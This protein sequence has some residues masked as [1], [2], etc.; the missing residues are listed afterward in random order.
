MKITKNI[1]ICALLVLMLLLCINACSANETLNETLGAD[2]IDEA[3]VADAP[4]DELSDDGDTSSVDA[5]E[6][7]YYTT[8]SDDV[9]VTAGE[10]TIVLPEGTLY[11]SETGSDENSGLSEGDSISTLAHAVDI[12]KARENKTATVYVLNGDYTTDAIDIGDDVGVSLSIIG[13]EKGGVTIHGNGA[14]VFDV[15]GD[16]LVWNFKNLDFVELDS[17]ARTSAALVLYSKNGNFTVDNCNFRDINSKLGAIAIGND[18]GNTNVT[19]CVIEDVTGSASSTSVLT[20]NGDGKFILD[21]VEIRNC[22]L[23]RSIASSNTASYLRT[24]IYINTYD[25]DVTVSNS[26]IINNKGPA[27]SLIESRSKL[28]IVNTTI[29]GNVVNTSASG[30]NGGDNLIW[31]NNDNS[32]INI[33]QCIIT[34]NTI[35]KSGKGLFYNQKGS[36]NIEYCD[37]SNNDVDSFVG[38]SGTITANNNWWGSNDQPDSKVDSWV[39]MNVE[40]DDSDLSENNKITLTVDFNHVK[41]SSG[42]VEELTGGEIPKD[43]YSI[44]LSAQNG[45]ITPASMVVQKGEVKSQ[46][47]TVTNVND[48]ITIICDAAVVDITVEGGDEPSTHGVIYV[49]KTGDDNNNG[50][51]EAPVA[52]LAKAIELA[53]KG[54][55]QIVIDEGTYTGYGYQVTKDL[56]I[57]GMGKVTLDANNQG[58]LFATGYPTNATKFILTNLTLAG[59]NADFGQVINSYAGELILDNVNITDNPGS[60]SLIL[61]SGK[62]TINNC[63]IANH[64]GG[65]V[66]SDSSSAQIVINNTLFENNTVTDYA[67]CYLSGYSGDL[68]IENTQFINNTGKLGIVKS[69]KKI[70]VKDSKFIDNTNTNSYG[71]AICDGNEFTI[72]NSTFINNKAARDGGAVSI[73]YNKVATITKSTFINNS[74]NTEGG[75]YYGDAIYNY[76]KLTVNYCV[77]LTNAENSLIYSESEYDVNAQY[78]WWGTNRNPLSLNGVGTYEDDDYNDV[79]CVIDS[80]NWVYMKVTTNL[81]EN[82]VSVGDKVG[83]TVD[84]TNYIDS[85]NALKPLGDSIPEVE[86]SASAIYGSL[87]PQTQTTS[88]NIAQFTYTA[89]DAGEDTVTIRSANAIVPVTINGNGEEGSIIYVDSINGADTNNGKTRA[90]AVKTIAHALEIANGQIVLMEGIHKVDGLGSIYEDLNITGEGNAIIDAQNNNRI[91]YVGSEGN[92]VISNVVMINGYSSEESGAL[93][94]NANYLTLIN[95]TLANSSAGQNYGG[96]IYSVGKL[97]LINTTIANC[98][99][100]EG[101]AIWSNNALSTGNSIV[102]RNSKLINNTAS[103]ND[104]LGGGAIFTQQITGFTIANTSFI[105]NKAGTTSSGGAIFISHSSASVTITD[106]EFIGNHA[107]G[108]DG[109]GGGAIYRTGTSNYQR[110]GTMTITNTLFENNTCDAN[111]GAIY[112][113]STTVNV[114]NSVLINNKDANGLAVYG[115]KTEQVSP[116]I[117]LNDNWWGSNDSPKNLVGG[118][119]NYK[120]T[121]NRWAVLTV[122]NDSEIV[123][124]STVKLTISINNYTTGTANGT[125]S[126]PITVPR[127]LNIISTY[128]NLNFTLNDGEFVID[129]YVAPNL[130]YLAVNVDNETVVLTLV[131]SPVM[132]EVGDITAKKYDKVNVVINVTS[133]ADVDSGKVELYAGDTLIDTIEVREGKAIKDVVIP[134]DVGTYE[135]I[136]RFSDDSG[137]FEDSESSATLTVD[138]ICELWNSTFFNFFDENGILREAISEEELVFHGN[139]SDLGISKI[140]INRP[141][142]ISGDDAT[143]YDLSYAL[144][145]DDIILANVSLIAD[146]VDLTDNGGAVIYAIGAGIEI[147]NVVVNY[148]TL[149]NKESFGIYVSSAEGFKLIDSEIY[150]DS[151]NN[152]ELI[153]QAALIVAESSDVEIKENLINASLPARDVAYNYY[154]PQL[155]GIYQDLVLGIGIQGGENVNFT[156]N[157]VYISAKAAQGTYATLDSLMSDSTINLLISGN[158]FTQRDFTGEGKAGYVNVVDLYNFNGATVQDNNILVNTSTGV[159]GLGTAYPIQVTGP[160]TGLLITK[161]N[162]TSVSR[163]PALGIYSQNYDGVTDSVISFNNIDVTGFA[164]PDE[165]ALVAGMELQDTNAKVFNNTIYSRSISAYDELN[166]LF[167]IS[168]AQYTAGSHAFD[169]QNNTVITEGKYAV[170]FRLADNSNV[171]YNILYAHELK[172]DAAARIVNGEANIVENNYPVVCDNIQ[173]V[174]SDVYAGQPTTITVT[175]PGATGNVTI[176]VNGIDTTVDLTDGVATLETVDYGNNY[177]VNVTYNGDLKYLPNWNSTTI[178]IIMNSVNLTAEDL[179]M[180]FMDGSNLVIKLADSDDNPIA[181]GLIYVNNTNAVYK[182]RT[183]ADGIVNVPVK[184]KPGEYTFDIRFDGE[185]A[186]ES[187]NITA[188]IVVNRINTNL[189]ADDLTVTYQEGGNYT[190]TLK[191]A[192]GN[193]ISGGIVKVDNGAKT[194][195]YRTDAN[196]V[197]NVP[198]SLK[199]GTY[200]FTASFDGNSKYNASSTSSTV[201]VNKAIVNMDALDITVGYNDGSNVTVRLTDVNGNAISG[202]TVRFNNTVNSYRYHTDSDGVASAPIKLKPGVYNYTFIFE[203][204]SLYDAANITRTVTINKLASNL[205]ASDINITYK[206]GNLTAKLTDIE[207][208]AISGATI[209]F[210]TGSK[211]CKYHTDSNGIATAP[212][213]L[214]PGEYN[215]TIS[216]GGNSLYGPANITKSVVVNK[217]DTKLSVQNISM[218][219]KDG[220]NYTAILTDINGNAISGATLIFNNTVNAYRYHTDSDG[221]ASAPINLKPGQYEYTVLFEGNSI[222]KSVNMT[223]TVNIAK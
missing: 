34:D 183:D 50:S 132:V 65:N 192:E 198:V 90:N 14:Y 67:I 155:S 134:I 120:P 38:A 168:Y 171:T 30:N 100:R 211:T 200:T 174:A 151:N 178:N 194:L 61:Q 28:T 156:A 153:H 26:R 11:V 207:G 75:D 71:G 49:N 130:M 166:Q 22:I 102:L 159:E 84:F 157:E 53:N 127:V 182:Y 113:R 175:V 57:T 186:Y 193:P 83:I 204:N 86:V 149:N 17:T 19:N 110:D 165:Y 144:R 39:I 16:N 128:E 138:G 81:T 76:G 87:D 33:A 72:T 112:A 135:L 13:Q 164:S 106:S 3:V 201:V 35:V 160:Y 217:I 199:P 124:G 80:S 140:T 119:R 216:F 85:T 176:S 181:G 118:Y 125:L 195:K 167:G 146:G 169:I 68:I 64:N 143:L 209:S 74:A 73:G 162:L 47:F 152:A 163:G 45:N 77:L 185:G 109:T 180:A 5:N 220:T 78:N 25:A 82:N 158:N 107:N 142:L 205:D 12:V 94:G 15:Y 191:D 37:I 69:N 1:F 48:V 123:E 2:S 95:C 7:G 54:L 136:A 147:N 79:D 111:G 8:I 92:V 29:S 219:F 116:A 89:Q 131:S 96:A 6:D 177:T 210:T 43:S 105:G 41:T 221:V 10:E 51:I 139:F 126:S 44:S 189:I 114:A 214:K 223:S 97:T 93:L 18:Y 23:D 213:D 115:Y 187:A 212:I 145:S 60:G 4:V 42:T 170:S 137:L 88:S 103:G 129:Y 21:N 104:N 208:N 99:A 24:L 148:T 154:Y 218:T 46:T 63:I 206:N 161:N 36:M 59:A 188:S 101:G 40:V 117:T 215:Y 196:G 9:K 27:M 150:F 184:L 203:G 133:Y 56:N 190:I 121:L 62:L 58:G 197:A 98:S 108:Q 173:V 70:T 55:G 20:V 122:T 179:V 202:V 31:A 91:L 141:I 172:G 32:D 52:S 222:Y 66:V